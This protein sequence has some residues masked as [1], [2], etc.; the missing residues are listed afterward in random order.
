MGFKGGTSLAAGAIVA[1]FL[2]SVVVGRL[3][4]SLA[5][6][7]TRSSLYKEAITKGGSKLFSEFMAVL[8][9]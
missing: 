8:Q 9:Y 7:K 1:I 3:R 2:V 4:L 6:T 5:S